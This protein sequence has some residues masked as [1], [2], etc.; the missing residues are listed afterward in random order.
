[1]D[2]ARHPYV[3]RTW[4]VDRTNI[5]YQAPESKLRGIEKPGGLRSSGRIPAKRGPE[6]KG[7]QP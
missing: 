4:M 5:R 6:R 7:R 2:K 1:M 3:V